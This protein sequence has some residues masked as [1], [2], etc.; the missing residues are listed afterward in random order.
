[1][2]LKAIQAQRFIHNASNVNSP[3]DELT[4]PNMVTINMMT[5]RATFTGDDGAT[6]EITGGELLA[7]N[8]YIGRGKPVACP[9]GTRESVRTGNVVT[10]LDAMDHAYFHALEKPFAGDYV[11]NNKPKPFTPPRIEDIVVKRES[12]YEAIQQHTT[13]LPTGVTINDGTDREF[14]FILDFKKGKL[15][16]MDEQGEVHEMDIGGTWDVTQYA[17]YNRMILVPDG[18]PEH[19]R[20]GKPVTISDVF[21][22]IHHLA[23]QN[24][25]AGFI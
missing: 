19:I 16:V 23:R 18:T 9:P 11:L 3:S 22:H 14:G 21:E 20:T 13:V 12:E 6:R 25:Y 7:P 2:A 4:I 10:L 5:L 24:V 15:C 1:M 8:N 17:G